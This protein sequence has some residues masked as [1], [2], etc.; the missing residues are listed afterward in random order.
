[1]GNRKVAIVATLLIALVILVLAFALPR[2]ASSLRI[3]ASFLSYTN[4]TN[5]IR[6]AMFAL[7]NHS[8]VTIR[9]WGFYRPESQQQQGLRP[10]LYLGPNVYLAPGKSEVISVATPVYSGV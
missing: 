2:R 10:A 7:T 5:G 8:E 3:T 1:M 4:D 6:L 9:R